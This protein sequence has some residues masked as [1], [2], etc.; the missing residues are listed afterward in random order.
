MHLR[1]LAVL[2]TFAALAPPAPA[3]DA[4]S[5]QIATLASTCAAC[6]GTQGQAVGSAL[7]PLAGMPRDSMLEQLRAF[8]AGT[9]PST[10][11]QQLSKGFTEAQL[12]Q[13]AGYFARQGR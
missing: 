3:Q 13:I 9:R 11:M 5:L 10:I 8:R 1:K 4:A 7:P 6:H 2:T 12:E